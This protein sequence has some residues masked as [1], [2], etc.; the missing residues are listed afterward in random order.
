MGLDGPDFDGTV[1]AGGS[2]CISVFRVDSNIH[3][4]VSV[5]LKNLEVGQTL[6]RR[7][8]MEKRRIDCAV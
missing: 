2:K 1:E 3:N 5:A 6:S 8:V 7:N 4:V